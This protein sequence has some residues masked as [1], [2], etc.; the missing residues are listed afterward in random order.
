MATITTGYNQTVVTAPTAPS[1][2]TFFDYDINFPLYRE[3]VKRELV[4]EPTL[5]MELSSAESFFS[6]ESMI[7]TS[8]LLGNLEYGQELIVNLRKDQNPLDR[9]STRELQSRI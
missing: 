8:L 2:E 5:K 9:K 3:I 1:T 6:G 7:D 4:D